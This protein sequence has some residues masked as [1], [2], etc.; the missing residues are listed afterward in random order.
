MFTS[1]YVVLSLINLNRLLRCGI[2]VWIR[3]REYMGAPP[4]FYP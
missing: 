1:D 4:K 2:L 3:E